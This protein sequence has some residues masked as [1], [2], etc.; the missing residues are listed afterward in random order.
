MQDMPTEVERDDASQGS[1]DDRPKGL[2]ISELPLERAEQGRGCQRKQTGND[3]AQ[4][5]RRAR[6]LGQ[7]PRLRGDYVASQMEFVSDPRF[8][9]HPKSLKVLASADFAR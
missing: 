8:V 3:D 7:V 1:S 2:E 6:N 9:P 4:R 5:D